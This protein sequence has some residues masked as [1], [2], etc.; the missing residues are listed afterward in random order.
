[1]A[2]CPTFVLAVNVEECSA[3]DGECSANVAAIDFDDGDQD[4]EEAAESEAEDSISPGANDE[5]RCSDTDARCSFWAEAG[6]CD[7]NPNYMHIYCAL[8]CDTCPEPYEKTQEEE[9]LL[10]EVAHYGEPQRVEVIPYCCTDR[11]SWHSFSPLH[12]DYSS[13]SFLLLIGNTG[14]RLRQHI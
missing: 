6:E 1:M 14:N 7:N 5:D 3:Q 11:K 9:Q 2:T 4:Y 12:S 8:S 10:M 13:S